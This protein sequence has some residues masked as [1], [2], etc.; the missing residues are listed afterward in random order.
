MTELSLPVIVALIVVVALALVLLLR[1]KTGRPAPTAL[2]AAEES[3]RSIIDEAASAV[4]D[5]IAPLLDIDLHADQ[6]SDDL[7]RLKGLGPKAASLLNGLGVHRFAQLGALDDIQI[8]AIDAQM[9]NF[10]GRIIRDKWVE[11]ARLLAADDIA[12][13]EAQFG[14]LG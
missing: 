6:P 8:T 9:G 12:G 3:H 14:K 5:V 2:P 1:A 11:Q 10:Q 13:F 7:T 4:E